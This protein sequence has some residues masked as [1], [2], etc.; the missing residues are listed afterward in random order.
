MGR[1]GGWMGGIKCWL[2]HSKIIIKYTG[3]KAMGVGE[4]EKWEKF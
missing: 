2:N 1:G 3:C 4:G